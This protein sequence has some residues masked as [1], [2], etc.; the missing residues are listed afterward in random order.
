MTPPTTL[1]FPRVLIAALICSPVLMQPALAL[2]DTDSPAAE[3]PSVLV[4]GVRGG[5]RTELT[6]P[7]PVDILTASDLRAVAGAEANLGQALAALLPSFNYLDQSNSGSADHVRAAQLRGLNPDQM[8]VLINGKRVHTTS[9]VNVESVIGLGSVAV[10]FASIP[11]NAVKRVEVLRDGA[12]AQYGSDAIAGVVNII[13]DDGREGGEL[14]VNTGAYHT[15]FTPTDRTITDGQSTELAGKYRLALADSGYL[16]VGV[17]ASHHQPTDRAGFDQLYAQ[18]LPGSPPTVTFGVGDARVDNLNLWSN[19]ALPLGDG[20]TGYSTLLFNHRF[21]RGDA[22]YREPSAPAAG[23]LPQSTGQNEDLHL[24]G[25][26]RGDIAPAWHYD[27]SLTFGYNAFR[28]GL[29]DSQNTTLGAAG[30]SAFDLGGFRFSQTSL[31]YDVTH[32]IA[33]LGAGEPAVL[34]LGVEARKESYQTSAGD[35]LSYQLGGAQGDAGVQP[36]EVSDNDRNI[37]GAYAEL[38]GNVLHKVFA[39]A[40][41]RFDH[42][43]D[44]GGAATGKLSA[45]WEF[46]DNWA[47]RGAISNNFRAPALA[48]IASAYAPTLYTGGSGSNYVALGTV[49]ILPVSDP[50]AQALGAQPLK[51]ERSHNLSAGITAQPLPSLQLSADLFRIGINDRIA[52]SEQLAPTSGL[53]AGGTYQFFTN[54]V[55]TDTRGAELVAAWSKHFRAGTFRLSDS[56]LWVS[57]QIRSI[58]ASPAQINALAN[59]TSGSLI[60]GLQ[61]QNAITTAIPKR[62]DVVSLTWDADRWSA[63]ARIT[64]TG[65]VTRVFDFGSGFVPTQTYGATVQLDLEGEAKLTRALSIALGVQN[66]ADRYPT[67]SS[68]DINYYGNLPYDF[69]SPIG[70]NGRYVYLRGR[71]LIP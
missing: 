56:S 44:V 32:E 30:P 12:G 52:L 5:D 49:N 70:F 45:R 66:V 3:L 25:G 34:A 36:D 28:Y 7:V 2:T 29:E 58:H 35:P 38:S 57:N 16:D 18:A 51:P 40:A 1:P 20:A 53:G 4:T 10:D 26:I 59:L 6:T 63:L 8:L 62:R 21:S 41:V 50:R 60:F 19:M 31:N 23:Y 65:E 55:D 64:H 22:F 47:L 61:A 43:S 11:V 9:I 71:Y 46:A 42:D 54:A 33:G 67:Q 69:L 39:D 27:A 24:S 13:L 17:D 48:Q 15:H 37:L 14:S 68:S